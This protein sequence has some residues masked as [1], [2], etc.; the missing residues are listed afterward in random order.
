MAGFRRK[1]ILVEAEQLWPD[2]QPWP[3]GVERVAYK[4]ADPTSWTGY[5]V[6]TPDGWV[7]VQAADWIIKGPAGDRYPCAPGIFAAT[8]DPEPE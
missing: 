2:K 5:R 7:S 3:E 4:V 6:E 8:Y 1:A